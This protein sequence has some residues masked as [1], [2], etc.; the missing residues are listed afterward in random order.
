MNHQTLPLPRGTYQASPAGLGYPQ[1]E[2]F[3]DDSAVRCYL[4]RSHGRVRMP[5][6]VVVEELAVEVMAQLPN[7]HTRPR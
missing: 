1:A 4:N 6:G 2:T 5:Y 7:D 3:T